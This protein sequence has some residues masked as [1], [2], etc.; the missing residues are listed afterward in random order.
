[1]RFS[2]PLDASAV[3]PSKAL[4]RWTRTSTLAAL[5]RKRLP[6]SGAWQ[7]GQF[8]RCYYPKNRRSAALRSGGGAIGVAEELCDDVVRRLAA[9]LLRRD[10]L[11]ERRLAALGERFV[12]AFDDGTITRW[13][14]LVRSRGRPFEVVATRAAGAVEVRASLERFDLGVPTR[15]ARSFGGRGASGP[16][17]RVSGRAVLTPNGSGR[18]C[19]RHP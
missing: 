10:A 5:P 16:P 2:F 15:R 11:G 8:G 17:V 12:G 7:W 6:P 18:R 3:N 9:Q 4:S 13:R 14:A 19:R 1:V